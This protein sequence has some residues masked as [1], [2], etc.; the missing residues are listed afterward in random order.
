MTMLEP[1]HE[2]Q[3]TPDG[4][5][6]TRLTAGT[7][8]RVVVVGAGFGGLSA[9]RELRDADMD[10]L[11]LDRNNYH[12]FWPFLYQVATGI[13]ETQEI[14]YPVR[15]MLRKHENVDFRM[16]EVHGIDLVGRQVLTDQES[17]PYDYLV[18]AGGSTTNYFGNDNLA[19]HSFGMK[20]IDDADRLRNHIL[21]AFEK[22]AQAENPDERAALMT[23]VIVGGGATGVEL[24]GQLSLLAHRTLPREFPSLDLSHTR[25]VLVNAGESVLESFPD[26]LRSDAR[27]RLEKM[28]VELRLGEVVES[29]E[30]GVVRFADGSELGATT[31]VWAAGVRACDLAGTLDAPLGRAGRVRIAPTLN[32]ESRPE[33]FVVGDMAYLEGYQG[34]SAYPMVAQVAMQQGRRAGRNIVA[35]ERDREPQ[36]FRYVDKGQMAIIGRRCA[37]VSAFGLRLRGRLAWMAWLS[38]HLLYLHGRRNRL[39]VLLDWL[40]AFFSPTRG[41]GIITR[42]DAPEQ[43]ERLQARVLQTQRRAA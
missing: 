18:L 43:V 42:S 32:L 28:G 34:D 24:A 3:A 31:V 11:V 22:A 14:A 19:E 4:H 17:Y 23:F 40:A 7:R 39:V 21:S 26:H 12:G 25:V 33:V 8:P 1:V 41:T 16:A 37:V 15:S 5:T 36:A 6:G 20:D 29:V 38:L 10:V 13:L 9:A 35:L 27:R 30:E 2:T